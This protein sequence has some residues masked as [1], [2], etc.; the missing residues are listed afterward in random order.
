M[1]DV[2]GFISFSGCVSMGLRDGIFVAEP[3]A[4][5]VSCSLDEECGLGGLCVGVTFRAECLGDGDVRSVVG[6]VLGL[7]AVP[8]MFDVMA[9]LGRT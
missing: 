3:A 1:A 7:E 4:E 5:S 2:D 6:S 9:F 8:V